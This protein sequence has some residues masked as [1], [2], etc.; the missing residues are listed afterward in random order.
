MDQ[1][2]S[3]A[4][5]WGSD[6]QLHL[7]RGVRA[8]YEPYPGGLAP[9]SPRPLS[10]HEIEA[11]LARCDQSCGQVLEKLSWSPS[12]ALRRADRKVDPSA[13]ATPIE[14]LLAHRLLRPLDSEGG[15]L[16]RARWPGT[17]AAAGSL[18]EPVPADPPRSPAEALTSTWLIRPRLALR[19]A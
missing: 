7:V 17:S 10:I 9:P 14:Q 2:R 11:A 8:A 16:A 19:S 18:A 15:D 5:L 12:G 6:D 1:L 4:L 3:L 13:A